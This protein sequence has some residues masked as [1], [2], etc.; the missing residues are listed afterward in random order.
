MRDYKGFTLSELLVTLGIIG[1]VAAL[2]VPSLTQNAQKKVFVTSLKKAYSELSQALQNAK[3]ERNVQNW[4]EARVDGNAL[5]TN[6][7]KTTYIGNDINAVM[8]L[9]SS[10]FKNYDESESTVSGNYYCAMLKDGASVCIAQGAGPQEV[11]V[12]TNGKQGPN[13]GGR[14]IFRLYINTDGEV[15]GYQGYD[16][17]KGK[18][19]SVGTSINADTAFSYIVSKGWDMDY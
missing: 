9:T 16:N 4:S 18:D 17:I 14:D 5:F 15:V 2:T 1:V 10:K 11:Y 19:D 3:T 12:D 13:I 7:L 6:Y 8:E